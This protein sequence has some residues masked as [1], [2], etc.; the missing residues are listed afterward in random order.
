VP[1][2][3][4]H[5]GMWADR[6]LGGWRAWKAGLRRLAAL[7]NVMVKISGL[8]MLD[9]HWTEGSIRPLVLETIDAFGTDRAMFASNFPVDKLF[10]TFPVLWT[11]FDAITAGLT[12]AE[13]TNL[14]CDNAVR[15]Y[16]LNLPVT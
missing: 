10:S 9:L 3:L 4:N 7:P 14:M 13:R 6:D 8:G 16:R 5:A 12:P 1:V 2:I 15:A 11:A